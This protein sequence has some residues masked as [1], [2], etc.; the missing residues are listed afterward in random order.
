VLLP[1]ARTK[2]VSW[3][4]TIVDDSSVSDKNKK[5]GTRGAKKIR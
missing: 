4:W 1:P 2:P 5:P 3:E